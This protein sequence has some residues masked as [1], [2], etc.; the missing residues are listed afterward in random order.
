[1]LF[2]FFFVCISTLLYVMCICVFVCLLNDLSLFISLF[3]LLGEAVGMLGL[4]AVVVSLIWC[5]SFTC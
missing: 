1:M 4:Y 3:L 5:I 2:I